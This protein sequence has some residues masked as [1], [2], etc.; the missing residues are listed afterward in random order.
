MELIGDATIEACRVGDSAAWRTL[1]DSHFDFAF[2]V[3]RRLGLT[4]AEAEDAVHEAFVVAFRRLDTF[5]HGVFAHWLYRIVSN[6]VAAQLRKQRVRTFFHDLWSREETELAPAAEPAVA[7]R[8]H[9]AAVEKVLRELSQTKREAFA[10]HELEGM[11]HE[12]IAQLTGTNVSTVRT[13]LHYARKDFEAIARKR[14]LL[15]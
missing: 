11:T 12:E 14:G 1:Y 6:V 7:A 3:A 13:R 8:Q 4:A 15:P 10:L 2:R 5:Q 9:L